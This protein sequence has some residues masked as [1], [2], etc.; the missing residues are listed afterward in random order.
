MTR[1][2]LL[3]LSHTYSSSPR[4]TF[5]SGR[6][7]RIHLVRAYPF[8]QRSTPALID[9]FAILFEKKRTVLPEP[10]RLYPMRV[11]HSVRS[12]APP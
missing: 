6:V 5:V 9:S 1:S 12:P 7:Y 8:T 3:A 10:R 4:G 2:C 11:R